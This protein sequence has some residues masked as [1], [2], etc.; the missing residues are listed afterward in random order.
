MIVFKNRSQSADWLVWHK[1]LNG[2]VPGSNYYLK[3][4][5]LAAQAQYSGMWGASAPNST[6]FGVT[7]GTTIAGNN[8]LIS[9]AFSE[10]PG[11]SK[12]GS[13]VGNG[14]ADGPFVHTGFRP[15][16][17]MVKRIDSGT[18]GWVMVDAVRNPNNVT[19]KVVS[20]DLMN[21]E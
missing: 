21:A 1:N 12:F 11:F 17:L 14:S 8:N 13:Y 10:V 4:N 15:K 9:Y 2:G 19:D 6:T 5:S 16:W 20:A 3:L 18:D 7:V